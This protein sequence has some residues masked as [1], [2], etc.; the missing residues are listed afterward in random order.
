MKFDLVPPAKFYGSN[1]WNASFFLTESAAYGVCEGFRMEVLGELCSERREFLFPGNY[2]EQKFNYV[3]LENISQTTRLLVGFAPKMGA[4]VKSRSKVFHEGDILYGRLRPSL[5]KCLLVDGM[6]S[7]GICST[8]IL[9]LVANEDVVLPE[10]LCEL[11]VST[12]VSRRIQCLVAGAALPRVQVKDLLRIEVPIPDRDAQEKVVSQVRSARQ[13]LV[14]HIRRARELPV[15][16][17]GAFSDFAF[18]GAIFAINTTAG[19]GQADW[20]NPLPDSARGG[21][22]Q[23]RLREGA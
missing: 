4:E 9:V 12:E 23:L 2:P 1:R 21:Q 20:D 22:R 7:E 16:I 5:N 18:R 19:D 13:E 3:G 8:E 17:G 10:Y 11:M 15:E 14:Q 6:L